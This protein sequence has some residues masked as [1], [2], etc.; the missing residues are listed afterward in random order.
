MKEEKR[1]YDS[2]IGWTHA[3]C[4][5]C[6]TIFPIYDKYGQWNDLPPDNQFYCPEC[7]RKGFKS[8]KVKSPKTST[9][10][11]TPENYLKVNNIKDKL[12]IKFFKKVC[13]ERGTFNKRYESILKEAIE[14]ADLHRED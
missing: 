3:V 9:G 1:A 10:R 13:R 8:K 6:K 4:K 2:Y 14:L 11:L 12:V 5:G 7:Q